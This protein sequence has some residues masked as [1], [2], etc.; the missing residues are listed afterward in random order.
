MRTPQV[1]LSSWGRISAAL[2]LVSLV[3]LVVAA[4]LLGDQSNHAD[5]VQSLDGSI[6]GPAA[7]AAALCFFLASRLSGKPQL[8]WLGVVCVA[9]AMQAIT[10]STLQAG[11][12]VQPHDGSAL[13]FP[14]DVLA[15]LLVARWS[16]AAAGRSYVAR[17]LLLGASTGLVLGCGQVVAMQLLPHA[18]I[19]RYAWAPLG[20]AYGV[21]ALLVVQLLLIIPDVP[22]WAARGL[23]ASIALYG[24]GHFALLVDAGRGSL[25]GG[26]V[27]AVA[28]VAG[29]IAIAAGAFGTLAV[30]VGDHDSAVECLQARV[31]E[32]EAAHRADSARSHEVRATIAGMVCASNLLQDDTTMA[33]QRRQQITKML[34]SELG[35]LH[36]L[37]GDSAA[38]ATSGAADGPGDG[39]VDLDDTIEDLVV[40]QELRGNR[41]RWL[42]SGAQVTGVRDTIAEVINILLDNAAKHGRT[43]T[44]VTVNMGAEAIEVVVADDGPGIAPELRGRLFDWGA[45]GPRSRGQGIG[46]NI[47]HDLT[48]R[49]GGYLRV[50]EDTDRGGATFV[51]GFPRA[52]RG[53][54]EPAHIA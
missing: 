18:R 37:V 41:V 26:I 22:R 12:V 34:N 50:R 42:P 40:A 28:D 20:V 31:D 1:H 8:A 19:E 39:V 54:D 23:A 51:A 17:P 24:A 36:R 35:R 38:S 45:R 4:R 9:V 7:T 49:Q 3:S 21:I 25:A 15:M 47:A 46:L 2:L 52:R 33:P 14:I 10:I 5:A 53:D 29:T 48:A 6:R 32:L 11:H 13:L 30:V 16:I 27:A 44:S 43:D